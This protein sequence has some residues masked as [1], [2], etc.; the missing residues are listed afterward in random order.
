MSVPLNTHAILL[1]D[2]M[3]GVWMQA[4]ACEF[5]KMFWIVVR[6]NAAQYNTVNNPYIFIF[7][8]KVNE[9]VEVNELWRSC[10]YSIW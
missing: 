3:A 10:F 9:L 6:L 5:T 4:W 2:L 8:E 7:I 1:V